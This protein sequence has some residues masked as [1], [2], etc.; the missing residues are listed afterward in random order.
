[1]TVAYDDEGQPLSL[2]DIR[3]MDLADILDG[4]IRIYRR[5]PWTFIAI[6]T[7]FVAVPVFI[8]QLA[9]S[10]IEPAVFQ[11]MK[12]AGAGGAL[13]ALNPLRTR[14]VTIALIT[15]ASMQPFV[16]FLVPIAQAA[17]VY[18]VSETLLGRLPTISE[19]IRAISPKLWTIV[20]AY[21]VFIG[22][23]LI[24]YIPFLLFFAVPPDHP[25]IIP[26]LIGFLLVFIAC[27]FFIIFFILKFL[28]IPHSIVLDGASVW[29][30]LR[31]SY[32]LVSGHWWRIFGIYLVIGILVG[33]VV[34]LL[35]LSGYLVE[36]LLRKIPSVT[37]GTTIFIR[38]VIT[39]VIYMVIN[40]ITLIAHVLLY[41]DLRIRKEGFDLVLLASSLGGGQKPA[42]ESLPEVPLG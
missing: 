13:E 2:I 31:R 15:L 21:L 36:M 20:L 17:I 23:I 35:G 4:T 16:F 18:A 11:M 1:M 37:A 30:S 14:T 27:F 39:T 40:P 42:E 38:S 3:P 22:I 34:S 25:D 19:S 29:G 12:I 24:F 6:L 10:Y 5:N 26:I 8:T 41:Y 32:T 7:A 28:F 33:I 9:N